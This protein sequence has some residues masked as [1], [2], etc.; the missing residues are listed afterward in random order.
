M[1]NLIFVT[2][3]TA[4]M[5]L[6]NAG[7][8]APRSGADN[9]PRLTRMC[10]EGSRDVIGLPTEAYQ[11]A[12]K[13]NDEQRG[14]LGEVSAAAT[15]AG[16]DTRAACPSEIAPTAPGRLAAMQKRIQAMV[17]AVAT[18]RPRLEKFYGLL[19]DEQKEQVIAIDQRSARRGLLTDQDCNTA[20]AGVAEWP[21]ADVERAVHPNDAQRASLVVLQAAVAKAGETAKGSCP[22]ESPLTPT[23]R[24]A[25]VGQRLDAFLRSIK[26]VRGP[27]DDFYATLDE[28]Q[29]A[30]FDAISLA[31][32]SQ[33]DQSSKA[34]AV[35]SGHRH[36][37]VNVGYLIRRFLHSF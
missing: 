10:D 19:D 33:S 3:V 7:V 21:I 23:A 27:L 35:A 2:A 30:R 8:A 20:Q 29:K 26:A 9:A 32:T 6:S 25:A 13:L 5:A 12:L 11:R 14:A 1:R 28:D 22:T 18:V 34:K 17:D 16:Q 31:Q 24:L 4:A 15:K 36:H 37:F